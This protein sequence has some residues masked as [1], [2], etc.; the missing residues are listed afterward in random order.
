MLSWVIETMCTQVG[1]R[2]FSKSIGDYVRARTTTVIFPHC[3]HALCEKRNWQETELTDL[4]KDAIRGCFSGTLVRSAG[5]GPV[6][7]VRRACNVIWLFVVCAVPRA[8]GNLTGLPKQRFGTR[9]TE[10]KACAGSPGSAIAGVAAI[11]G[12]YPIEIPL[13]SPSSGQ[14]KERQDLRSGPT[15]RKHPKKLSFSAWFL[16]WNV[17]V[18][19]GS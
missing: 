16:V 9:G 17:G 2:K 6:P 5:E 4:P 12:V 14:L 13:E 3:Y 15:C 8:R 19:A 1:P 11:M 10:R 18:V 7:D